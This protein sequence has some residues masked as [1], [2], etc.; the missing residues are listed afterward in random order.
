MRQAIFKSFFASDLYRKA[1][2][3]ESLASYLEPSF[4]VQED[5]TLISRIHVSSEVPHLDP[6]IES[7]ADSAI[8]LYEFLGGLNLVQASDARLWVYL[9][10]VTFREYTMERWPAK[11]SE[12]DLER[13]EIQ[14]RMSDFIIPRWFTSSSARSL[15]RH[16]LSRLWWSAQ[17]TV[18]P[19]RKNRKIFGHLESSDPYIYTRLL[20]STQDTMS[21]ILGRRLGWSDELRIALLEFLRHNAEIREN[22]SAL[23]ALMREVNLTMGYRK[24]PHLPMVSLLVAISN[25]KTQIGDVS[26]QTP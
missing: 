9:S 19:W 5:A 20:F 12:T 4:S 17:L 21:Q 23:R 25:M 11:W 2:S 14:K 26:Q 7:D 13:S 22:R 6:A 15:E 8:K 24:L 16:A 18:A 3:G 1:K 10:H